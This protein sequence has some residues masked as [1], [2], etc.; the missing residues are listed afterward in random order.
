MASPQKRFDIWKSSLAR[1]LHKYVY[2]SIIITDRFDNK[3]PHSACNSNSL[4]IS[5]PK[6]E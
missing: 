3:N 5:F 6:D 2:F 1:L 4:K